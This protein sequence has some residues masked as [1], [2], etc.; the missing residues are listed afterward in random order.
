MNGGDTTD[1]ARGGGGGAGGAIKLVGGSIE[2]NGELQARGGGIAPV[3]LPIW[4]VPGVGL[5]LR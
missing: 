4:M 2:N 5:P 1:N 3:E